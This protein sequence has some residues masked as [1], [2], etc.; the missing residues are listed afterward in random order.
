VS[1]AQRRP[2]SSLLLAQSSREQLHIVLI[3]HILLRLLYYMSISNMTL[4]TE[5]DCAQIAGI[6]ITFLSSLHTPRLLGPSVITH[7]HKYQ[8]RGPL[9]PLRPHIVLSRPPLVGSTKRPRALLSRCTQSLFGGPSSLSCSRN[10]DRLSALSIQ[11]T[12][13]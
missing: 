1:R 4:L 10:N 9:Y 3:H 6:I 11:H 2:P 8:L 13:V 5:K 7:P 12:L